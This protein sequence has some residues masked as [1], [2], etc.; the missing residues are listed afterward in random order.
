MK[1]FFASLCVTG[2]VLAGLV[3]GV[4]AGPKPGNKPSMASQH[5]G[6]P[7]AMKFNNTRKIDKNYHMTHG[8]SFS[9]GTF[10]EGRNHYHWTHYTWWPR[11][12][13]YAYWCPSTSC[14]YYWSETA[15][16]YYP[17]SYAETVAPT[18]S[19]QLLDI[20][21]NNNNNNNNSNTVTSGAVPT[22]V[23]V[24]ALVG[25][26]APPVRAV[27]RSTVGLELRPLSSRANLRGREAS[28][29]AS[30]FVARGDG[31]GDGEP[32]PV[33]ARVTATVR[34]HDVRSKAVPFP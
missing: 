11:F 9:H 1:A 24:P 21:V 6:S 33:R 31:D 3:Q 22:P 25:P 12:G 7:K 30:R 14:Y 13:C 26:P 19:E 15:S 5:S 20:N 4:Q 27:V 28:S 16:R 34:N 2:L 17:V 23:A 32:K 8:R 18:R 29:E 10:Y